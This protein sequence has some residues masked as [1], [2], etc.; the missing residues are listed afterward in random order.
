MPPQLPPLYLISDRR[1]VPHPEDFCDRIKQALDAGVRML[2]LREKDLC[3]GELYRLGRNLRDLTRR[4]D[5]LLLINDRIDLALALDADG[6]H[7]GG[8]SL[9]TPV[10]R[11]LL[12]REK[13]IG[14]STHSL[15][16]I[17]TATTEGADFV[18]FSPIY[19]SLSKPAYGPPQ[20]LSTLSKAC[21]LND[22][23]V[24][25][26]GGIIPERVAEC[27]AAG[28]HGVALISAI[29]AEKQPAAVCQRI[30]GQL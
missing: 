27:R 23:P 28:A 3:A 7:L 17:S 14:V 26:L 16:E 1:L 20:G 8:K 5:A 24:Y 4:Y 29:L 22:I 30:L 25:A 6:V 9:P 2:Q 11:Q 12:G 10:A 21:Q 18:T 13:L 19:P 15:E